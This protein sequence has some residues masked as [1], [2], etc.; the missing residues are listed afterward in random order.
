VRELYRFF[1]THS[2]DISALSAYLAD[3]GLQLDELPAVIRSLFDPPKP[4]SELQTDK[5]PAGFD[6][7]SQLRTYLGDPP[8]GYEWHHIIEQTG[9]TRDDLTSPEG[10]RTWIQN[11]DNVVM[12]PVIKHYCINGF[13]SSARPP[14]SGII[15]RNTVKG[16]EPNEQRR[17][18]IILLLLCGLSNESI[19][20]TNLDR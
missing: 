14:G 12:I 4:L 6:R 3:H 19:A 8:P 9:Q 13:M 15:L 7:E 11:T 2:S 10:I 18:G 5:P 1:M 17:V 20:A 16:M